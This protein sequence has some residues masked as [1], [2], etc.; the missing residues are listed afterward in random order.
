MF[1]GC[2]ITLFL[3]QRDQRSKEGR[4]KLSMK[5]KMLQLL[6]ETDHGFCS[7]AVTEK[8]IIGKFAF[9]SRIKMTGIIKWPRAFI[10]IY[11]GDAQGR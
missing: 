10:S 11:S 1:F 4:Q 6:L 7:L 9:V 2:E 3:L 8:Q 5:A